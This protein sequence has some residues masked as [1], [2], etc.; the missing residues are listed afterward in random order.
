MKILA[1]GAH[2]DD[3]E[4]GCFATLAKFA[5][6]GHEI[7]ILVCTNGEAGLVDE[8]SIQKRMDESKESAALINAKIYFGN[9]PDTRLS[10]GIDTIKIIEK[11][12]KDINPDILFFNYRDDIHQDHRHLASAVISA[13]RFTPHEVYMYESP[14]TSKSFA[15]S[16]YFDVT[17]IFDTKLEAVK[18]HQS[19]GKKSYM[20]DRAIRGL[21]EFRAFEIGLN[22]KLVEGFSPLRI[23]HKHDSHKYM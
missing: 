11:H 23:L 8:T 12:V 16:V 22:D 21:A 5:K 18:I 17:D 19:Q 2:P 10:D 13:T 3:V 6:E 1:I 9:L 15:P 7:N 20:A 14:S 4:L